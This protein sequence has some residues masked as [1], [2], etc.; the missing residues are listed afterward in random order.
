M[1]EGARILIVEDEYIVAALLEDTLHAFGCE[2]VGPAT[3]VDDALDLLEHEEIDAAVLDVNIAGEMVFPVADA[4]ER[5]G[6]PFVFS[7]AYG[8]RGVVEEHRRHEIL[9]KPFELRSLR[10]ALE[11]SLPGRR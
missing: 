9:Q 5:R 8:L 11:S 1:L 10:R 7:T 2:V 4:L 6:I 3:R